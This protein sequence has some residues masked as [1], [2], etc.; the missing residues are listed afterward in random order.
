MSA[1]VVGYTA[2]DAG[3]DALALG[4]RIAAAT[5]G[6]LDLVIVLPAEDR[7]VITPPDAGYDRLLRA[8][9]EGWLRDAAARVAALSPRA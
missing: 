7:S 8:T 9:A 6:T 1:V 4:A 2:T 5:G 3:A